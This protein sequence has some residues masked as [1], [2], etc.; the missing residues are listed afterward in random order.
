LTCSWMA[1]GRRPILP[2]GASFIICMV[3]FSRMYSD[4]FSGLWSGVWHLGSGEGG[5]TH[6]DGA[7]TGRRGRLPHEERVRVAHESRESHE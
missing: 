5:M 3:G 1:L 2:L 7:A 4:E 6:R